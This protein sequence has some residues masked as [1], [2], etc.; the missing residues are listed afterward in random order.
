MLLFFTDFEDILNFSK[1]VDDNLLMTQLFTILKKS[2]TNVEEMLNR[3]LSSILKYSKCNKLIINF[4]Q[5]E[6]ETMLFG[7]A[8]RLELSPKELELYY[9][10]T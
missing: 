7:T 6:I 10:Q 8:K 9:D 4:D 5:N 2:V 3:D 1:S